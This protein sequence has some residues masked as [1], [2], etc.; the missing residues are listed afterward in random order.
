MNP[1]NE[2]SMFLDAVRRLWNLH[3]HHV[4]GKARV[5]RAHPTKK[6]P[7]RGDGWKVGTAELER[8]LKPVENMH[9]GDRY[10]RLAGKVRNAKKLTRGC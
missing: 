1:G 9:Y 5:R 4:Q 3:P 7:G 10:F 2:N 6:G 8:R